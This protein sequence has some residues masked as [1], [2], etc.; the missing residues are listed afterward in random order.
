MQSY[1]QVFLW[2]SQ[3]IVGI[4]FTHQSPALV[5]ASFTTTMLIDFIYL[6]GYLIVKGQNFHFHL[7][8]MMRVYFDNETEI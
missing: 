5:L 8:F 7:V 1:F 6:K 2:Y 3:D 4:N